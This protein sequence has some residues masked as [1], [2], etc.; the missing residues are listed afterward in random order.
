M[1]SLL[2]GLYPVHVRVPAGGDGADRH[3]FQ[4]A[5]GRGGGRGA[6]HGPHL[7]PGAPPAAPPRRPLRVRGGRHGD[8]RRVRH[9]LT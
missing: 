7:R 9:L 2:I 1:F 4:P 5:A 3:V 6:A 8:G